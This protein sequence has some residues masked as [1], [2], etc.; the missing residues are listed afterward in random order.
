MVPP[1]LFGNC[2][3][4]RA[5]TVSP[6]GFRYSSLLYCL[7]MMMLPLKVETLKVA[8]PSPTTA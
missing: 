5:F 3:S 2:C 1:Q 4:R 7:R 6:V 8:P